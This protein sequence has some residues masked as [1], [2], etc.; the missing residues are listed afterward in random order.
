MRAGWVQDFSKAS[1]GFE[2]P[3]EF[4]GFLILMECAGVQ[5]FMPSGGARTITLSCK[6]LQLGLEGL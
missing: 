4:M 2:E 6:G 1:E 5:S 3:L